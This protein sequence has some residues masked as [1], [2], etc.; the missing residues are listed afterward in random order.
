M[1]ADDGDDLAS[2]QVGNPMNLNDPDILQVAGLFE[3]NT[4]A[5]AR[6]EGSRVAAPNGVET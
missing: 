5:P 3:W 1:C 6:T 4:S 2:P